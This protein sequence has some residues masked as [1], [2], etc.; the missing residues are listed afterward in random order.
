[1]DVKEAAARLEV[2]SATVYALVAAG[3]L[4]AYRIGLGKGRIRIS[5]EHIAEYLAGAERKVTPP[6][7]SRRVKLRHLRL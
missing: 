1:M 5:E 7:P 3:K 4:R 6:P 2:S